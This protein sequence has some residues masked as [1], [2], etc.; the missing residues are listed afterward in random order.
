MAKRSK[1]KS[2]FSFSRIFSAL[3]LLMLLGIIGA[4]IA[5]L[6]LVDTDSWKEFDPDSLTNVNQTLYVYDINSNEIAGV[7]N[8]ENRTPIEIEKIPE[9]VKNAFIAIED[10]R[11]YNHKGVDIIRFFGSVVANLKT[12]SFGQGFS[13]ISQQLIKN[14]HLTNEKTINRKVQEMYLAIMLEREYEKDEIL[15]MYLNYV[16]FG[17]GAYG[18]EA[19]AKSYF[20]KSVDRLTLDEGAMLAGIIKAPGDYAPHLDLERS[21]KRRNLVLSQMVEYELLDEVSA[22][23]TKAMQPNL[24]ISRPNNSQYS[25]F[26]DVALDE[27][28]SILDMSYENM[29]S[30]GYKIYTTMDTAIQKKTQELFSTPEFF[31]ENAA[32][33]TIVEA[34]AVIINAEN[35]AIKTLIGGR[36]YAAKGLNRAINARR[37]PGSAIKPILVYGPAIDLAGYNGATLLNDQPID[38]NGYAPQNYSKKFVGWTSLREAVKKS[39]NV[40][41]V[42]VFNEIGVANGIEYAKAAGIPFDESDNHLSLALGGFKYGVTP[43]ELCASYQPLANEGYYNEPYT[44]ERIEDSHGNKVYEHKSSPKQIMDT[45]TAFIMSDIL[46]STA[47]GGTAKR[48]N[49]DGVPVAGKTGTVSYNKGMGINDAWTVAYTTQ[50][51]VVVWNGYDNPSEIHTMP[52]SATGGVYPA[53]MIHE[54]LSELYK[55]HQPRY[56]IQSDDVVLVDLDKISYDVY[57][58]IALATEYTPSEHIFSEYFTIYNKPTNESKYWS[59]PSPV[60]DLRLS[61]TDDELPIISFTPT[62]EFAQYTILRKISDIESSQLI[63]IATIGGENGYIQHIDITALPGKYDYTVIP[64]NPNIYIDQKYLSAEACPYVSITVPE[65]TPDPSS[66][67]QWPFISTLPPEITPSPSVT[68]GDSSTQDKP[69]TPPDDENPSASPTVEIII[70]PNNDDKKE[71]D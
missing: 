7:Y 58:E 34:A 22:A 60:S 10:A 71:G 33:G 31:P 70:V 45:S 62:L 28:S 61:L 56:Y 36:E 69:E 39:L 35:G 37:Q 66:S 11:F 50:D 44:V 20:D 8:H 3:I 9:H 43:L 25:Q 67:F 21:I 49:V 63:P 59:V 38:F 54:I 46:M 41:A 16:Y 52:L 12:M 24:N 18:I 68:D 27:A 48:V 30:S 13:T 14:T 5:F 4:G 15:E 6:L 19:A 65:K 23:Q 1:K 40:P 2:R 47:A 29:T 55:D 53:I 51:L 42:M 57:N 17:N 64:Y 32:D 26:V